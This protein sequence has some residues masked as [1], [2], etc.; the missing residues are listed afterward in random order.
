MPDIELQRA[1]PQTDVRHVA[2]GRERIVAVLG[3]VAGQREVP[4]RM[5]PR[6]LHTLPFRPDFGLPRR[7]QLLVL[8]HDVLDGVVVDGDALLAAEVLE[9]PQPI[10]ARAEIVEIACLQIAMEFFVGREAAIRAHPE[11]VRLDAFEIAILLERSAEGRERLVHR[12]GREW[13]KR[14]GGKHR[15]RSAARLQ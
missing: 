6:L 5:Q 15:P 11:E 14:H 2:L 12:V 3:I 4:E 13:R 9:P 8:R 10:A 1:K 7:R